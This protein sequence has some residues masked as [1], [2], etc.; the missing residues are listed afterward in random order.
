MSTGAEEGPGCRAADARGPGSLQVT[1]GHLYA[2]LGGRGGGRKEGPV[3]V[4]CIGG[5]PAF[6]A[7]VSVRLQAPCMC[8]CTCLG[9][10]KTFPSTPRGLLVVGGV[11]KAGGTQHT[12]CRA[13]PV[14]RGS[15]PT[16]KAVTMRRTHNVPLAVGCLSGTETSLSTASVCVSP[17]GRPSPRRA[18]QGILAY[19]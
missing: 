1:R 8:M 3:C 14:R 4:G 17:V 13:A 2:A 10:K 19:T 5:L 9:K 18:A 6:E 7:L 16:G 15:L 11:F 12:S